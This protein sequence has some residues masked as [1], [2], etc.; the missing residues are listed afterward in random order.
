MT[1]KWFRSVVHSTLIA[2]F[3]SP[4]A[5]CLLICPVSTSERPSLAGT[6]VKQVQGRVRETDIQIAPE[7][8]ALVEPKVS[9]S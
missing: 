4:P 8:L 9:I 1:R 3:L 5:F 2:T 6:K 7:L